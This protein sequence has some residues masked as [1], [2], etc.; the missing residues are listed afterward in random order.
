MLKELLQLPFKAKGAVLRGAE[1]TVHSLVPATP[2]SEQLRP[3]HPSDADDVVARTFFHVELTITP[4]TRGTTFTQ[5]EPAELLLVGPEFVTESDTEDDACVISRVERWEQNGFV[6]EEAAKLKGAQR[7]RLLIGV[8][9][10]H[11]SLRLQYY[12]EQLAVVA[13]PST[14]VP[15]PVRAANMPQ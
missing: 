15:I 11:L 1:V 8:Q 12:F 10:P 2:P 13:I 9:P 6:E 3:S 4:K 5:W 14:M 7:L